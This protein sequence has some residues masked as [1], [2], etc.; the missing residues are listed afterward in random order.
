MFEQI[1][2]PSTFRSGD[3]DLIKQSLLQADDL[4]LADVVDTNQWQAIFDKHEVNFGSDE[5]AVYTPA[6]TLW[7]LISHVFFKDEMRSCKAAVGRV[8]A[9]WATR[10]RVAV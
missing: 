2:N 9:L 8:A 4:P 5:D 6:I 7:A 3:F 10:G 1:A